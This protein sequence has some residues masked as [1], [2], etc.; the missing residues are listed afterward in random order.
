MK[1]AEFDA[2]VSGSTAST[3]TSGR[4]GPNGGAKRR[5]GFP[6]ITRESRRRTRRGLLVLLLALLLLFLGYRF[7]VRPL[8]VDESP[9]PPPSRPPSRRPS[10]TTAA[11]ASSSESTSPA[12][13]PVDEPRPDII[14]RPPEMT[15]NAGTERPTV[16]ID[17]TFDIRADLAPTN[18][19]KHA[20]GGQ[21]PSF[22]GGFHPRIHAVAVGE[23]TGRVPSAIS[24]TRAPSTTRRPPS[25]AP[26]T[27]STRQPPVE[28]DDEDENLAWFPH[29][30]RR[31]SFASTTTKR[32]PTTTTGRSRGT[33]G[34]H[35]GHPHANAGGGGRNPPTST[36]DSDLDLRDVINQV[37][38]QNQS[39]V[40]PWRRVPHWMPPA[41]APP[42]PPIQV[43]LSVHATVHTVP[44]EDSKAKGRATH[45][46]DP[47]RW[48]GTPVIVTALLDIG[49]GEWQR[50]TRPYDL[51]LS[52]LK[53]LL[54]VDNRF[55]IYCDRAAAEYLSSQ[56]DLDERRIQLVRIELADLPFYRE[57]DAIKR[58]LEHE[59]TYWSDQWDERFKEHPEAISADY[60]LLVNSKPY[61]MYN[62]SIISVFKA[63]FFVWVDA[64]YGHGSTDVIPEGVW[65]PELPAGKI[66][67]IQVTG[68]HDKAEK[69]TLDKV[70]RLKRDVI[71]GGFLAGDVPT[72]RRFVVF[73]QKVF[74]EKMLDNYRV[75]DDQTTLLLTIVDYRSEFNLIHAGW[76]DGFRMLPS[77]RRH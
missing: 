18:Q 27:T 11:P 42:K 30:P 37:D 35:V 69:Y 39:D 22:D 45:P 49:R 2:L 75:D 47:R 77:R 23:Q 5:N 33:A 52:Y 29:K 38:T 67:L 28:E 60:N 40:P 20:A 76:F 15:W 59:Q 34:G 65:D 36:V 4:S 54:R 44:G 7:F 21:Q 17:S 73:F 12:P 55:I 62:A 57:R 46:E 32:P 25:T 24:T 1:S 64:G 9:P 56:L 74:I 72:I 53:N 3:A 19:T 50:F 63:D 13:P 51:Y 31:P 66:S 14:L 26:P 68:P 43:K 10:T 6:P 70:Y 16:E 48:D 71:S 41:T 8:L 58:I 61:L